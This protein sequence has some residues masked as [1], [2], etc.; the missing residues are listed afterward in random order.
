S[1]PCA[2]IPNGKSS[3]YL[4]FIKEIHIKNTKDSVVGIGVP[5]KYFDFPV[6][7]FGRLATVTLKRARRLRPQKTKNVR[8]TVSRKVRKP[9]TKAQEAG[10]APNVICNFDVIVIMP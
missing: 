6:S 10:A 2:T 1:R 3:R 5:S 7:S 4:P 8:S 9:S